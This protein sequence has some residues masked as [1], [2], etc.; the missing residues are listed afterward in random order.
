MSFGVDT[1]GGL[2]E[3]LKQQINDTQNLY[4]SFLD[5]NQLYK[6]GKMGDKDFFVKLGEYLV[7]TSALNFLAVRVI[8]EIKNALDKGT[9][10]KS[11]TGASSSSP[12]A[13]QAGFGIGGFVGTGGTVGPAG[14]S[15]GGNE[16]TFPSPQEPT[17]KPVDIELPKPRATSAAKNCIACNNSIP[18]HAK[19]CSK[20]GRPQ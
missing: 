19:F 2:T 3:K 12:S 18:A 6:Q 10:I 4:E 17:L 5:A 20:C 9:S 8:L 13:P 7:S 1:L 11:P 16:Y 14:T 15:G